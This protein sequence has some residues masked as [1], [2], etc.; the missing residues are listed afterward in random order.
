MRIATYNVEWFNALFDD[1]AMLLVDQRW[2]GRYN[3]TRQDQ[4]AALG[5]VFAA[6]DADVILLVEAPDHST[7]RST[8]SA[9]QQF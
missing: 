1:D 3:V 4:I 9:L 2:S 8:I 6:L 5:V 7:D